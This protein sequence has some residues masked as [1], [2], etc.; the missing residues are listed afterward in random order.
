VSALA[1]RLQWKGATWDV[2]TTWPWKVC[3]QAL[4]RLAICSVFREPGCFS[5]ASANCPEIY[6]DG[7]PR[8]GM[9]CK[10]TCRASR[11][12]TSGMRHDAERPLTAMDCSCLSSTRGNG[13]HGWAFRTRLVASNTTPD[14]GPIK[15]EDI[16]SLVPPCLAQTRGRELVQTWKGRVQHVASLA[17]SCLF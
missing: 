4:A 17:P 11:A 6:P 13:F 2:G 3:F 9:K 7:E 12:Y 16:S 8:S 14:S 15:S 10:Q 5:I 1:R